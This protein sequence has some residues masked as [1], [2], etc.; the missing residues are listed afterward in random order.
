[1][2]AEFVGVGT[3]SDEKDFLTRR[4][5]DGRNQQAPRESKNGK[6][7]GENNQ[8]AFGRDVKIGDKVKNNDGQTKADHKGGAN[9]FSQHEAVADSADVVPSGGIE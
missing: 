9:D 8:V 3:G 1:M 7:S 4:F 2:C 6:E 5:D